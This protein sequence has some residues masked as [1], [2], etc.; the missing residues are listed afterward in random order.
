MI[1]VTK[2]SHVRVF[3]VI[4]SKLADVPA[5]FRELAATIEVQQLDRARYYPALEWNPQVNQLSVVLYD[6]EPELGLDPE[7]LVG[8]RRVRSAHGHY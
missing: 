6:Q 5:V 8:L 7:C 2:N 3:S 4:P 1:R